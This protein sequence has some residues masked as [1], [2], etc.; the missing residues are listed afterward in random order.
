MGFSGGGS[1]VLLPHTHDGRIAQ[2]GGALNFANVTQS[3]SS[4][5]EIFYSDKVAL[6][7]LTYPCVPAGETLT[8]AVASTAPSWAASTPG[9]HSLIY[10][11]TGLTHNFDTGHLTDMANFRYLEFYMNFSSSIQQPLAFEFY[12]PD[13]NLWSSHGNNYSQ[14]GQ[15]LGVDY[16]QANTG[17]FQT[18]FGQNINTAGETDQGW[19]LYIKMLSY[20]ERQPASS[21]DFSYFFGQRYTQGVYSPAMTRQSI[22]TIAN[23]TTTS[24]DKQMV[25]GVKMTSPTSDQSDGIVQIWGL[26]AA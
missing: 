14:V 23:G 5:G 7:Q 20:I 11:Q 12:D 22:G 9:G 1:S 15:Y 16:T 3:Q 4:A 13:G 19:N 26:G 8:A 17:T 2:D 10:S 6:Q 18:T 25:Q 24:T 21:A